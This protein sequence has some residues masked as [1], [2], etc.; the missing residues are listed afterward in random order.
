[1]AE[2]GTGKSRLYYEFKETL[3]AACRTRQEFRV[4]EPVG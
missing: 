2:A 3:P 1:V 4:L